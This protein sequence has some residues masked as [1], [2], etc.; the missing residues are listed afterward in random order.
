MFRMVTRRVKKML[1]WILA[2]GAVLLMFSGAW[3]L[4]SLAGAV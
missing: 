1:A 3:W 4:V 2:I